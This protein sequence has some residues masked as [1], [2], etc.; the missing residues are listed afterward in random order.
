MSS[1]SSDGQIDFITGSHVTPWFIAYLAGLQFGQYML[2][3]EYVRGR[4]AE[5]TGFYYQPGASGRFLFSRLKNQQNGTSEIIFEAVKY[6]RG[7]HQHSHVCIV[8]AGMHLSR[9]PAYII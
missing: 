4:I 1:F 2:G 9:I 3:N 8:S 7:S 5:N 6:F